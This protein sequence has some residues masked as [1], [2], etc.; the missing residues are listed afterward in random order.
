MTN[1]DITPGIF[2]ALFLKYTKCTQLHYSG[3]I[4]PAT[5]L[6]SDAPFL[7]ALQSKS[8]LAGATDSLVLVEELDPAS[9]DRQKYHH[10]QGFLIFC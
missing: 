9:N 6:T 8:S 2:P 10:H 3:D 4:T 1:Q 7:L 5:A